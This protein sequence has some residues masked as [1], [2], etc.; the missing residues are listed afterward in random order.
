MAI[1]Y[2]I[3]LREAHQFED[4]FKDPKQA[5]MSEEQLLILLDCV[6]EK[7]KQSRYLSGDEFGIGDYV[8]VPIL[9]RITVDQ[10]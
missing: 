9:A 8:F 7:L 1:S 10:M 3:K 2:H 6:E 4:L 5:A